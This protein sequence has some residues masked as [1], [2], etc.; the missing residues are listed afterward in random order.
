MLRKCRVYQY[1][2]LRLIVYQPT[3]GQRTVDQ[4][5]GEK[6]GYLS[7]EHRGNG[8]LYPLG[9]CQSQLTV[10]KNEDLQRRPDSIQQQPSR[11]D[12]NMMLAQ[13]FGSDVVWGVAPALARDYW[14]LSYLMQIFS[15]VWA[16]DVTKTMT[17]SNRQEKL[18]NW[19]LG[20][21]RKGR[22]LEKRLRRVRLILG[23]S[24][25]IE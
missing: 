11:F 12:Y 20:T 18:L 25:R 3:Q 6:E 8:P 19:R 9:S 16:I 15:M 14:L 10:G 5:E 1:V 17:P 21:G 4:I 24:D 13:K 23:Q 2:G 22:K 7:G